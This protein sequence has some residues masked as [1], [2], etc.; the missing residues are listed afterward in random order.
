[1]ARF[2]AGIYSESRFCWSNA[3]SSVLALARFGERAAV[4]G[5]G[6]AGAQS[7]LVACL[8]G[9]AGD[10]LWR[11]LNHRVWCSLRRE[12]SFLAPYD[13]ESYVKAV[14][15]HVRAKSQLCLGG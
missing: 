15:G 9:E 12:G 7:V 3:T 1:M 5:R 8:G 10:V 11:E 6:L 4:G 14:F 13:S 2:G